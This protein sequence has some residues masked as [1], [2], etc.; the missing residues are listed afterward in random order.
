MKL[1][2][3]TEL[4]TTD[5]I[6]LSTKYGLKKLC[7]LIEAI[8]TL[9]SLNLSNIDM[10]IEEYKCLLDGNKTITTL[11]ISANNIGDEGCKYLLQR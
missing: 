10:I 2:N 6:I 11:N 4:D 1:Q 3:R 5:F 9:T 7:Q 8:P